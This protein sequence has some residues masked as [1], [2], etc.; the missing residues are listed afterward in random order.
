M[1]NLFKIL[2]LFISLL[3]FA[4]NQNKVTGET[5]IKLLLQEK[6]Y[7]KAYSY[8]DESVKSKISEEFLKTTEQ[9]LENQLGKFNNIIEI[10]NENSTYFYYADFEKMKLDIKINLNEADKILGFFFVPHQEFNKKNLLG[11]DLNIQIDNIVLK[12]TILIPE[13][14]NLKKLVIFVHGSGPQDRDE[15]IFENKP[16]KDISESLYQKGIASYRFDK[17]TLTNPESYN[18]KSTIDDEVTNDIVNIIS[19]FKENE[20]FKG[21]E[22]ILLGHSLGANLMPRIAGKSAQISKLI[23]L[24]GNARSLE[25]LIAEQYEYLYKQNPSPELLEA[26]KKMKEQIAVLTSKSFNVNT[27]KEQLPFNLSGY[28]WKSVLDYDALKEVKN[29]KIP[30]LILQGERDY[31]VT[32]EDFEL[33]KSTLKNNKKASFISYPKLNHLFMSGENASEPKEYMIKGNVDE[34]VIVDIFNF[35]EKN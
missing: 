9:Q 22:I 13:N 4:Q 11:S 2:F 23:L 15:T 14:N 1:K 28:Y 5:F 20:E 10:N 16:F 7:E 12:G 33:W 32:M 30:M 35:I 25:K 31:Q 26:S 34:K 19:Y 21:Y 27:P 29:V 18:Y 3:S 24:A 17:K 8:F 6:N